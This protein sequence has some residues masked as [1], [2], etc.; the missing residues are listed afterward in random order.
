MFRIAKRSGFLTL[1]LLVLAGCPKNQTPPEGMVLIPAGDFIM[2][3]NKVDTEGKAAEFGTVKP[4]YL[5]EHPQHKV[6]LPSYFMDK[7]EVTNAAYKPFVDATGSRPPENWPAGKIPSGRENYPVTYVN[8]YDAER[9]CQWAG[10]RLPTEAQWEKAA[11]GTDGRDYPWGNEFDATKANTGDTGIGDLTPVGHFEAGKSPYG[12]YD[13][14]GNVWEWTSDW[15][16]PYAGSDYTSETFGEKFKVIRGSS[17][18]GMGH[19]A[20]PYF[21]R[22]SYRFYISPEGAFPDAG[23][24]CAKDLK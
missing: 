24:R 23:F 15:Y 10:K 22:T 1:C 19:Y 21:Y 13:M 4:W 6:N 5:D 17:W 18:G 14:A 3:S 12:V 2:G 8:W 7:Y 9:F 20:I 16:Q 11:R